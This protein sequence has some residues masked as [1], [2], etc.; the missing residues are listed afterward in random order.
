MLSLVDFLVLH[1]IC[2]EQPFAIDWTVQ[3]GT[4]NMQ[5]QPRVLRRVEMEKRRYLRLFVFRLFPQR[6]P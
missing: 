4:E 5:T 3:T 1:S 2:R 6:A